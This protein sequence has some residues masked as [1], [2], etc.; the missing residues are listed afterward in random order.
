MDGARPGK[1]DQDGTTWRCAPMVLPGLRDEILDNDD[2]TGGGLADVHRRYHRTRDPRLRDV[3]V[4]RHA[5]LVRHLAVRFAHRG[6]D[7]DDLIQVGFWG[8]LLAIE[9]FDPDYGVQFTTF[10]TPTITGEL[11]RHFRDRRWIV[12]VPRSVKD[13]YVR[14]RETREILFQDLGHAPSMEEIAAGAGLGVGEVCEALDA[15][16]SFRPLPLTPSPISEDRDLANVL[17][18]PCR[19]LELAEDR[20]LVA[21]LLSRLPARERRML[22]LRFGHDL[23]QREIAVELGTSQMQVSRLLARTLDTLRR[24]ATGDAPEPQGP[25]RAG[26]AA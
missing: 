10:A 1:V 25:R 17:A 7:V 19:E 22:W 12:R 24:L 11:K 5:G 26:C 13:N 2:S 8:L 20:R 23:S 6:E 18:S 3:L 16:R 15:A 9:R 21:A 14:V 4:D